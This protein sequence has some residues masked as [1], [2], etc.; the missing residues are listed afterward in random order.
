MTTGAMKKKVYQYLDAADEHLLHIIY[1]LLKVYKEDENKEN[2]L[3][4][5]QKAEL[6]KTL[7]AHKAG[8]LKYHTLESAKRLVNK[9]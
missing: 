4:K 7:T 5:E 9:K 8:R 3:T 1:S 2:L 6:D